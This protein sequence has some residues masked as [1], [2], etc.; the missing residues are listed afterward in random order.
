MVK[1]SSMMQMMAQAHYGRS[2]PTDRE[3]ELYEA[4]TYLGEA[5]ST[6][7]IKIRCREGADNDIYTVLF[8]GQEVFQITRGIS[9]TISLYLPGEWEDKVLKRYHDFK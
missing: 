6:K 7:T 2:N 5:F 1:Y 4:V 3:Q 8:E 9:E